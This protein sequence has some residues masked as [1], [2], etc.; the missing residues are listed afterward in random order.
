M[1]WSNL[2]GL[3]LLSAVQVLYLVRRREASGYRDL[4]HLIVITSSFAL[5][6]A[7]SFSNNE[8]WRLRLI[9]IALATNV[10]GLLFTDLG[11]AIHGA[12]LITRHSLARELISKVSIVIVVLWYVFFFF[13]LGNLGQ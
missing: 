3:V 8:L 5:F 11:V 13:F 12:E 2:A 6:A 1:P 10:T 4:L 7:A 9:V